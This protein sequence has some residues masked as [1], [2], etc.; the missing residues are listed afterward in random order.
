MK[1]ALHYKILLS[2]ALAF[3]VGLMANF[4]TDDM[5]NKPLWF[6]YL[7][8]CVSILWYSLFECIEDGGYSSDFDLYHLRVAKI[9]AESNFK[10]T[11]SKDDGILWIIGF[12]GGYCRSALRKYF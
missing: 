12:R 9:G 2:L 1:L 11:G 3:S 10:K 7:N 6:S 8:A 4:L 5:S